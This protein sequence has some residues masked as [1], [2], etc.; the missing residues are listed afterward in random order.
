MRKSERSSGKLR[1]NYANVANSNFTK[2]AKTKPIMKTNETSP[3]V[4]SPSKTSTTSHSTT[5]DT[6]SP[7]APSSTSATKSTTNNC[8]NCQSLVETVNNLVKQVQ[9]LQEQVASLTVSNNANSAPV[10]DLLIPPTSQYNHAE[11]LEWKKHIE[12]LV[13]SR[14]NRQLRKTLV[15]RGIKEDNDTER[16][17]ED[18]DDLLVSKIA[19][20][21]GTTESFGADADDDYDVE[22]EAGTMIDRCH[23]GGNKAFFDEQGR[24][25]P[26]FAAMHSW[27]DCKRIIRSFRKQKCGIFVDYKYGPRTTK[28]RNIAMMHRRD[29]I[30]NKVIDQGYIVF[31]AKLVGRKLGDKFYNTIKDFSHDEV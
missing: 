29:L 5:S 3:S 18:T 20:S 14:T 22:E 24:H 7:P 31:P 19:E 16:T 1:K 27:K 21:L 28:R 13:E 23:R 15:F 25:R 4:T 11:F 2:P 30:R 9:S 12:E 10:S 17:W 8:N 6:E 26:I